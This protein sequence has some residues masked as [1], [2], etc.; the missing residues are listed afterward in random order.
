MRYRF[1]LIFDRDDDGKDFAGWAQEAHLTAIDMRD[2]D[3]CPFPANRLYE[4]LVD[5][6]KGS[7]FT[8]DW[9]PFIASMGTVA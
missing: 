8:D 6:E 9:K 1:V 7:Q 3:G 5:E 4:V 2:R